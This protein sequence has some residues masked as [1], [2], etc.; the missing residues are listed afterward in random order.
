MGNPIV[1]IG[2]SDMN[3][4]SNTADF[5][6]GRPLM[7]DYKFGMILSGEV[8]QNPSSTG[9]LLHLNSLWLIFIY[10]LI[11]THFQSPVCA[12]LG[13][14]PQGFVLK[15]SKNRNTYIACDTRV[16]GFHVVSKKKEKI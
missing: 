13:R 15:V 3:P 6:L 12:R 14:R 8:S 16:C 2:N 9:L 1:P 10:F 7:Q 4:V 11:R 5:E